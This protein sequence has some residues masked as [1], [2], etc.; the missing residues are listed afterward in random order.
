MEGLMGPGAGLDDVEKK[1]LL[2]LPGIEPQFLGYPLHGPY[3]IPVELVELLRTCS[4][5]SFL[6]CEV[7]RV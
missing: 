1:N 5:L 4:H 7:V 2:N 6:V 3:T